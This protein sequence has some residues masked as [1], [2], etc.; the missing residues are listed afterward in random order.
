MEAL[1]GRVADPEPQIVAEHRARGRDG[2]TLHVFVKT[3]IDEGP[4]S[5]QGP[6]ELAIVGE[7]MRELTR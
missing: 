6:D 4:C 5:D 7:N 1:D 3:G 2:G